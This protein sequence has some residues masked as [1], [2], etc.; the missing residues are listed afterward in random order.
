MLYHK[1]AHYAIE[2]FHI[3]FQDFQRTAMVFVT[4]NGSPINPA[5]LSTSL[6]SILEKIR[7]IGYE[8]SKG[9]LLRFQ[10]R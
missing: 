2:Y 10:N 9:A 8:N 6:Q 5:R 7:R 1:Q 4:C 3:M